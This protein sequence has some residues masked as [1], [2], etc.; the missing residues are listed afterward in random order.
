MLYSPFYFAIYSFPTPISGLKPGMVEKFAAARTPSE[1]STTWVY[2][3]IV[4]WLVEF[5][6]WYS[7]KC[8][9]RFELLK[10]YIMDPTLESVRVE[11]VY[12]E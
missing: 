10:Q 1:K 7:H 4:V 11:A 2:I 12:I 3:H 6:L 5:G 8:F 9:P